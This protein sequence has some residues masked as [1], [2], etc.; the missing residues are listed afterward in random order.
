[1]RK[2]L[3][4]LVS[5]KLLRSGFFVVLLFVLVSDS[6]VLAHHKAIL[7]VS[8]SSALPQIEAIAE[9]PG[10]ILPDSPFFFLD[11]LKQ[12]VRLALSF[13]PEAKA[14]LHAEI[15]GERLAELRFMLARN[16]KKAAS[17]ALQGVS[18]NLRESAGNVS[19][20]QFAGRDVKKLAREINEK[21]KAKQKAL[22]S[23][24]QTATGALRLHAAQV[25][26]DIFE[27]KVEVE[28]ALPEE[29][30]ENEIRDD[31]A[32]RIERKVALASDSA[33]LLKRDLAE[34]TREASESATRSLKRR[35]E[36]LKKAIE[37]ADDK[38]K[39]VQ[40]KL[41]EEEKKKQ[42]GLLRAQE[43]AAVQA[44]DA[45]LRAQTAATEFKKAQQVA[46]EIRGKPVSET[47]KFPNQE[48]SSKS[49]PS[50]N[51]GPGSSSSGSN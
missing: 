39:K 16:N 41:L 30:L 5:L 24:E 21:I 35:E 38:E 11:R 48:P 1:M 19:K 22:D 26:E 7:G 18:D 25:Q 23:F 13:S 14:K 12:N 8:T 33:K 15:A 37:K 44:Q 2:A 51:S 34:L 40:Q 31:L 3:S 28:D 17:T 27:S 42:T 46:N 32:R 45:L 49:G 50:S 29:D 47:S 43:R 36:A 6:P 20:A 9:G 10:L 4:F